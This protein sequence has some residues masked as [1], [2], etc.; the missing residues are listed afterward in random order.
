MSSNTTYDRVNRLTEEH[1]KVLAELL[2]EKTKQPASKTKQLVA[3]VTAKR[4]LDLSELKAYIAQKLPKHMV[5][6]LINQVDQL[7]KLPNGKINLDQ[8]PSIQP[9]QKA[10]PDEDMPAS[11]KVEQQMVKIWEEVLGF[12]PIMVSDNFFEIGGDSILSI[13]IVA[14]S[15][16]YGLKITT[17][18]LFRFQTIQEL[19]SHLVATNETSQQTEPNEAHSK[20]TRDHFQFINPKDLPNLFKQLDIDPEDNDQS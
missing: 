19:S 4:M 11:N 2:A 5:P 8:L 9:T 1:R 6:N 12:E 20:E 16:K 7:P 14:K 13:Q 10:S 15:N 3:Y 17:E 18:D